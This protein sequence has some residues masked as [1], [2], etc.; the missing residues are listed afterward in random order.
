MNGILDVFDGDAFTVMS[1]T[2]A[3]NRLPYTPTKIA[4]LG[5]FSSEGV[6]TTFVIVEGLN[7]I[8]SLVPA[9]PRGSPPQPKG[10]QKARAQPVAI[11]HLPQRGKIMADEVQNVR[12]FGTTDTTAGAVAKMT[13]LQAIMK[14]DLDYT[15][16]YHRMGAIKGQ[17]L[18]ADGSVIVDMYSTFGGS[19]PTEVFALSTSSTAT[20][21]NSQNV[22]GLIETALGSISYDH[23]HAFCSPSFFAALMQDKTFIES[24]KY[25]AYQQGQGVLTKDNRYIGVSWGGIFWEVYRGSIASVPFIEAD[26]AYVFPVGVQ[27]MFITR[28]GPADYM[29]TVNTIGLPYYTKQQVMDFNKGVNVESQSNCLNLNTRPEA[30]LKLTLS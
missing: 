12:V 21:A 8:L 18:N 5:L 15:I 4:D 6:P 3:I 9:V 10:I 17:V 7:G 29:E 19:L 1:L 14:R 16:E 27:D 23:I 20:L 28:Y 2:A 26:A 24:L 11:P 30:V 22:I 13:M 25:A